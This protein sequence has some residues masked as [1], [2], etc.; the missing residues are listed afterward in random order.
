VLPS[1]GLREVMA[2]PSVAHVLEAVPPWL[3]ANFNAAAERLEF[4]CV[5]LFADAPHAT[6]VPVRFARH[7]SRRPLR[8][9][10][11]LF[12]YVEATL[13]AVR[14]AVLLTV[15]W[16]G[17]KNLAGLAWAAKTGT[18]AIVATDSKSGDFP[19][20]AWK[21][22]VKRRLMRCYAVAWAADGRAADYA[23][24]LGMPEERVI[25]GPVDTIDNAHFASGADAARRRMAGTRAALALPDSYFLVV[26]RLAPEKNLVTLVRA[27]SRY[28]ARAGDGAWRL[29]IA[30]DGPSRAEVEA[31]VEACGVASYVSLRGWVGFAELPAYYGLAGAFVLPS[32]RE[33]W[34]CVVNEAA[35]AG[36]PLLVSE[37]AGSASALVR[38][39][40]NGLMFDPCD[41]TAIAEAMAAVASPACDR[42]AMGAASREL[43]GGWSPQTYAASLARVV[44]LARQRPPV[45]V[46]AV[47]T[48]LLRR[49][50]INGLGAHVAQGSQEHVGHG[51]VGTRWPRHVS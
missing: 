48:A 6:G 37:R 1:K 39:G 24:S 19:R 47:E 44:A 45:V 30:G 15:G 46:T 4:T 3:V 23:V 7:R 16:T 12:R 9:G 31:A 8:C 51:P 17:G 32:V 28:C 26:C 49:A 18:P 2:R 35:A 20:V 27:Y 40:V 13:D 11:D 43:V 50:A 38:N 10:R 36:L 42:A 41:E 14:P 25:V 33:T 22:A 21:E 34:G 29:V 5:E